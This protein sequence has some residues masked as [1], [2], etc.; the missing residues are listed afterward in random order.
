[1]GIQTAKA[2]QQSG[3]P[4][5]G[6]PETQRPSAAEES[7]QGIPPGGTVLDI[8]EAAGDPRCNPRIDQTAF[9]IS[10]YFAPQRQEQRVSFRELHQDVAHMAGV[11]RRLGFGD[12]SKIAL[13]ETN[14]REFFGNYFGGMAIGA[15][16]IAVNLLALQ[17]ES[18]KSRFLAHM[19][20][21]PQCHAQDSPGAHA[22]LFGTDSLLHKMY[23]LRRIVRLKKHTPVRNWLAPRIAR[24]AQEQ[25]PQGLDRLV[26]ALLGRQARTRREKQ[27]LHLL[28]EHLPARMQ[29][30]TPE[31]RQT[32]LAS[33]P[34]ESTIAPP[35]APDKIAE[36]LYTSGTAGQPKGV[37][38]THANLAFTVRSL[39]EA[40]QDVIQDGDVLLMGLPFFHIFGKAV[41][42]T[43]LSRQM[44][45][46]R[47]GASIDM[48]LLPSLSKAI[49]NLDGVLK[50]IQTYQVTLVPAVPVFLEKLVHYLT[51]HPQKRDMM[52]SL[53]TIIS[54]G[55]ALKRD[56]Y[57]T[58]KAWYPHLRIIEGYGSSEGGI[59][60]LNKSGTPGYVGHPLPGIETHLAPLPDDPDKGQLWVRSSGVAQRYVPGTIPTHEE[61]AIIQGDGWFHTGDLVSHDPQHGY[62][63]RGRESFFIKIDNEK[64]SPVELEDALKLAVPQIVDALVVAHQPGVHEK[65]V[66][67]VICPDATVTEESIKHAMHQLA[68]DNLI[69]RWKIPKHLIVIHQAH[70]PAQFDHPFK[71]ESAYK[72]VRQ[73]LNQVLTPAAPDRPALVAF[74][75]DDERGRHS[76]TRILDPD[77]FQRVVEQYNMP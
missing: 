10:R 41:L 65:A 45:A 34:A 15:T 52:A 47:N 3:E 2:T 16:M 42:L 72:V 27:D 20:G 55:A 18:S 8:L 50:T 46:A 71:R 49:Q 77:G 29:V 9:V 66:G 44:Q 14:S 1:M 58:L 5:E 36:V 59:N 69:T 23:G 6:N 61:P 48:V 33:T 73:F 11:Y 24:F 25:P 75:Q 57:D 40:T 62:Q 28:F 19:L 30:I 67:V 60:L 37:A 12:G 64:R 4:S 56:T 70:M 39:T 32:L 76:R 63:I 21:S 51:L 22:Y 68:K 26:F 17:D 43:A 74:E 31:A 35:L 54:G 53:R 13:A 38:L 7:C